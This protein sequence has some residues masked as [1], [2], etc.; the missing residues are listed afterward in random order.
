MLTSSAL[1]VYEVELD[2]G[3]KIK[4]TMEHKFYCSDGGL[5]TLKA[6]LAEG[7]EIMCDDGKDK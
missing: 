1:E 5:H 2:N 7:L 4:A 6:I 3:M